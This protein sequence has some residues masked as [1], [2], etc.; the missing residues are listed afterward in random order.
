MKI[1]TTFTLAAAATLALTAC[2]GTG[3]KKPPQENSS[4]SGTLV[5][6]CDA[7]FENIMEQEIEVF[8]FCYP[9]ASVL[10]YYIDNRSAIDSLMNGSARVA[11]TATP[12]TPE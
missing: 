3:K 4:T 9:H 6:A 12:L 1:L 8:E 11:V 7:S 2:H 10:P 5:M